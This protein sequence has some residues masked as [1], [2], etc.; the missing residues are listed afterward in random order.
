MNTTQPIEAICK[1]N[2]AGYQ[3]GLAIGPGLPA[4]TVAEMVKTYVNEELAAAFRTGFEAGQK[5]PA[6]VSMR[7]VHKLLDEAGVPF[8]VR[9][10]APTPVHAR[11]SIAWRVRLLLGNLERAKFLLAAIATGSDAAVDQALTDIEASAPDYPARPERTTADRI[12]VFVGHSYGEEQ[13]DSSGDLLSSGQNAAPP[14]NGLILDSYAAA[15]K[16]DPP[17]DAAQAL[18]DACRALEDARRTLAARGHTYVRGNLTTGRAEE[19]SVAQCISIMADELKRARTA[20]HAAGISIAPAN[21]EAT[22]HVG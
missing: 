11:G 1:A 4:G 2:L 6:V 22:P 18:A 3:R 16:M 13:N 17:L 15:A 5:A 10:G 12:R 7:V 19:A 9:F 8:P 20:L 21:L 14:L